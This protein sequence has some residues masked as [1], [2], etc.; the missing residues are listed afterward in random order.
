MA[1]FHPV[2]AGPGFFVMSMTMIM[3]GTIATPLT[4]AGENSALFEVRW[5]RSVAEVAYRRPA[6]RK[7]DRFCIYRF[8][9]LDYG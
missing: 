7:L 9:D 1:H 3:M 2:P 4:T 6:T 8:G 5:V